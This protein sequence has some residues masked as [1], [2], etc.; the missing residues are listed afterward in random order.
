MAVIVV[1]HV[2]SGVLRGKTNLFFNIAY[3]SYTIT[4]CINIT[5]KNEQMFSGIGPRK[6]STRNEVLLLMHSCC[7]FIHLVLMATSMMWKVLPYCRHLIS[8]D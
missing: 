1:M 2:V 4:L 8:E 6:I 5:S 7:S 3:L